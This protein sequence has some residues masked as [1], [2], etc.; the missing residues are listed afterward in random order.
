MPLML[1]LLGTM[2][3]GGVQAATAEPR[4]ISFSLLGVVFPEQANKGVPLTASNKFYPPFLILSGL[5]P[6]DP[7][8]GAVELVYTVKPATPFIVPPPLQ[9]LEPG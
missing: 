3:T 2:S 4:G 1:L 9:R 7:Q 8:T 5:R 6:R